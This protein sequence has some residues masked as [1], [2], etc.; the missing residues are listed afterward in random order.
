MVKRARLAVVRGSCFSISW[1]P[2]SEL[3]T[4]SDNNALWMFNLSGSSPELLVA[5]QIGAPADAK[6]FRTISWAGDGRSVL[7]WQQAWEGGSRAILDIPT[8]TI[9]EVP[10]TFTYA[11]PFPTEVSW[12]QDDRLL[13]VRST[14]GAAQQTS[15]EI[16]RIA[17]EEGQLIQEESYQPDL[18]AAGAGAFHLENGRFAYTL[19]NQSD[20]NSTGVYLQTSLS[21]QPERVNGLIPTFIAPQVIWSPDGTGAIVLQNGYVLYAPTSGDVLYDGTAVFGT[22]AHSFEWLSVGTVPR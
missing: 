21:E 19:V 1:H 14:L 22:T 8:G 9:I 15:I 20:A 17:L 10:D 6:F 18:S 4:W 2:N 3:F 5:N 7:L 11:E 13:I 12:M 16:W